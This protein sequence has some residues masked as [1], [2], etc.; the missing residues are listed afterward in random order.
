MKYLKSLGITIIAVYL[1]V[2]GML[3]GFQEKLIFRSETLSQ[4]HVFTSSVD[5]EELYF[6][7]TDDA[8]LHGLH[9]KQENPQG[10]I[11]YYHGNAR[12]LEQW[13][14]WA[15]QL[16]KQYNYDVVIM[17]YRGYG[18]SM[19]KRSFD[20]MLAD[21]LLFYDYAKTKF[22]VEKI[23]I[24]GRSLGGA[25]ATHVAKERE[26]K[27]LI[28][29]ST[30]TSVSDIASKQ[31]WFLPIKWFLKYPFQNDRNITQITTPT[32]IIHG[33]GD[34]V[35]PYEHGEKLH[36]KARSNTKKLYTFEGGEHNNL[37]SYPAYFK[38]LD[39]I[40]LDN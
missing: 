8:I 20:V 13:G 15:E 11:V 9:Y 33:T 32:Y 1:L 34:Y 5:F 2:A 38:A 31:F 39:E 3:I 36:Q 25:F 12:T 37:T 28:L 7:A 4:D 35:V 19:G 22:P 18:K 26:A 14:K 21:A 10:V 23:T 24:F 6:K 30:F 40:L 27:Q 17:D 16:S 29:E